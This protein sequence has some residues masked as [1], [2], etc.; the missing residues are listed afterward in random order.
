MLGRSDEYMRRRTLS[1]R[2]G[3]ELQEAGFLALNLV[4]EG[5]H[6]PCCWLPITSAF[7]VKSKNAVFYGLPPPIG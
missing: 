2:Q 3:R 5:W 7:L 1:L 6:L 4:E